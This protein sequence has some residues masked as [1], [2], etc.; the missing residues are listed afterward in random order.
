MV[1][2]SLTALGITDKKPDKDFNA[3]NELVQ[4]E[5]QLPSTQLYEEVSL[6]EATIVARVQ[7]M[8]QSI[9]V[10]INN[11]FIKKV[12]PKSNHLFIDVL[13]AFNQD[14]LNNDHRQLNREPQPQEASYISE[15]A[16]VIPQIFFLHGSRTV[17][18]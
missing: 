13:S 9:I 8:W 14:P 6:L 4:T 18:I 16:K 3:G 5:D 15:Y 11:S 2:L 1:L 17:W 10:T 12:V 7:G